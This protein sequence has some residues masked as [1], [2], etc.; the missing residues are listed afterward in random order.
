MVNTYAQNVF[1][2]C[3]FDDDYQSILRAII[4][5]VFDCGFKPRTALEVSDAD[6]VR[7]EKIIR[8]IRESRYSIHDISR[9]EQDSN[10][11]L[12]RFNMP[13]EFGIYFGAR[14][15]GDKQQREK[16]CLVMDKERYRYRNFISDISG[17]D[18][19]AH[20][21]QP[22]TAIKCVR[23]WLHEKSERSTIPGS[24]VIR[25]RYHRFN[26]ELPA[27]CERL[28]WDERALTYVEYTTSVTVWLRELI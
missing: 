22:D 3:P 27:F 18:I 5:T 1:I 15:F 10:T 9:T 19:R 4:F 6:D 8:I 21:G 17:Q 7:I 16:S 23:D 12:P 28:S 2:N 20:Y 11:Q 24:H 13:F 14:H 26:A 25:Q